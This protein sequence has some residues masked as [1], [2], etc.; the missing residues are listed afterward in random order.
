MLAALKNFKQLDAK[1]KYLFLGDMFELGNEA[2]TEHQA[3]TDFVEDN[4]EEGIYLIGENFFR[5]KTKS[6]HKFSSFENL[7]PKL[8][9]LQLKNTTLLIKG[10]RG[11]AL[12]RILDLI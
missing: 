2:E 11:M 10:S 9:T 5:T 6:S 7:K 12:E 1:N 4:F 3:I 8:K